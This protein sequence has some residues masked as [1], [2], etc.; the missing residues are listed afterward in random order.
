MNYRTKFRRN[1]LFQISGIRAN[2]PQFFFIFESN[3]DTL[4]FYGQW[5]KVQELN[6]MGSLPL[7]IL[8]DNPNLETWERVFG[9]DVLVSSF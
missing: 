9:S 1:E 3:Q 4:H 6:E 7:E 2:Y 8:R 5:E